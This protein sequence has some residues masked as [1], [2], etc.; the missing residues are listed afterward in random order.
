MVYR[1]YLTLLIIVLIGSACNYSFKGSLPSNIKTVAVPLF[2]DRTAYP[3][4]RED[5]TNMVIDE[6]TADNTLKITAESDA[7]IIISGTISSIRQRASILKEGEDV[8]E[9]QLFVNVK[10]KCE[11]VRNNKVLWERNLSQFGIMPGGAS[12]DDRDIAIEEALVKITSDI[13]NNTL[14]YW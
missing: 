1:N 10:V 5:L 9:F 4:V 3:G 14:G 2:D 13:L 11:D 12:Q 7:D 8:E 6:F